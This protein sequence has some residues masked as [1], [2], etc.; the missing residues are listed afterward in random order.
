MREPEDF[1]VFEVEEIE[2]IDEDQAQEP[3]ADTAGAESPEAGTAEPI[4]DPEPASVDL[5]AATYCVAPNPLSDGWLLAHDRNLVLA[6]MSAGDPE[7]GLLGQR[8]EWGTGQ[9]AELERQIA[10]GHSATRRRFFSQTA[11]LV[12]V[13]LGSPFLVASL[14][15]ALGLAIGPLPVVGDGPS[16]FVGSAGANVG[17][18]PLAALICSI[19]GLALLISQFRKSPPL[20]RLPKNLRLVIT[21]GGAIEDGF[22]EAASDIVAEARGLVGGRTGLPHS[23]AR[24]L[25]GVLWRLERLALEFGL[26]PAAAAYSDLAQSVYAFSNGPRGLGGRAQ[27]RLKNV[28][29]D[30]DPDVNPGGSAWLQAIFKPIGGIV[31]ALILIAMAGVFRLADNEFEIVRTNTLWQPSGAIDFVDLT[32]QAVTGVDFEGSDA[33][34][35]VT[36][37]GWY[38]AAPP[39]LTRREQ[40][41]RLENSLTIEVDI[42]QAANDSVA[43]LSARFD[44]LVKEPR[45]FVDA[46]LRYPDPDARVSQ[47][48]AE[49]VEI[50]LA[51]EREMLEQTADPTTSTERLRDNMAAILEQ[52]I[53]ASAGDDAL[54]ELG[55]LLVAVPEFDLGEKPSV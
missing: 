47:A 45:A 19:P 27:L 48:V 10:R 35:A 36:G 39:P 30:Y 22:L 46:R 11:Y 20:P 53:T 50:V 31:I 4:A 41:S 38:W 6:A 32:R 25:A 42:G 5:P 51:G 29:A 17:G 16:S 8:P 40:I 23:D 18:L 55:V 26:S 28:A 49:L 14:L 1:E 37:P 52:V 13:A 12:L 33:A 24:R 7:R 44:Y 21:D 3:A 43:T 54:D 9:V 34:I 15:G 2:E